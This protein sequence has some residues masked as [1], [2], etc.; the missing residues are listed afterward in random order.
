M[1]KTDFALYPNQAPQ[2]MDLTGLRVRIDSLY[3]DSKGR[4]KP[5]IQRRADKILQPLRAPL[6]KLLARDEVILYAA[7]A[8]PSLSLLQQFIQGWAIYRYNLVI[9][10]VT[11][12]RLLQLAVEPG[13]AWKK[14]IRSLAWGDV[15]SVLVKPALFGGTL[16]LRLADKTE[17]AYWKLRR[18]DAKALKVILPAL[19]TASAGEATGRGMLQLCPSCTGELIPREYRCRAC[20]LGFKDERT[21]LWRALAIPGG[22]YFYVGQKWPGVAA[23]IGELYVLIEILVLLSA[24]RAA[25]RMRSI[26]DVLGLVAALVF[27]L[28]L[29]I[30]EKAFSIYHG[31]HAVREFLPL[32]S[33]STIGQNTA[34]VAGV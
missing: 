25:S 3:S 10:I 31:R 17:H 16:K 8:T 1:A 14:S 34:A 32:D 18:G 27:I 15:A 9:L 11:N 24:I 30:L 7:Q 4:Q 22:A 19:I 2:M 21:L 13:G 28:A 12:R 5:G 23:T 20:G 33:G 26:K 6:Q 29:L